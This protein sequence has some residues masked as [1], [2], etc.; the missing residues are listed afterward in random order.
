MWKILFLA[1]IIVVILSLLALLSVFLEK[2]ETIRDGREPIQL[3]KRPQ[4]LALTIPL[5]LWLLG[6]YFL[7]M[8][9]K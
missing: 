3:L 7:A 5:G 6:I 9:F 2:R 1:E 4:I 8:H